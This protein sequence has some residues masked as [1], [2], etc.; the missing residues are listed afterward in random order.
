MGILDTI[1]LIALAA[2]WGSSFLFMRVLAPVLGPVATADS[3]LL[4]AG[5]ALIA[6]FAVRG[7]KIG[8][9]THWRQYAT[10]GIVNSAVPFLLF[11]YAALHLPASYS[12]ILNATSPLFGMLLGFFWLAVRPSGWGFFGALLGMLGV[13]L[14]TGMGAIT[15]TLDV[16]LAIAACLG[17]AA[18]YAVAGFY[19]KKNAAHLNPV[20]IAGAAQL[21]AGLALLPPAL[22]F[23]PTSPLTPTIIACA[24]ALA[25]VC[26]AMAYLL[27]YRLIANCG[28]T[29]ALTVTFL[30]PVFGVIWGALFL[31]EH[32]T[33]GMLAGCALVVLGAALVIR[34]PGRPG[35]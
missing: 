22:A 29:R 28:P 25:L 16:L 1:R 17:A 24:L 10:I 20:A 19:M 26:S 2:I 27:Y 23:P 11:S 5:L 3:R 35:S 32:L 8:W 18:C 34:R 15:M 21:V 4:I 14:I 33:T 9:R 6:W 30:I 31:D 12:A 7:P 13:G